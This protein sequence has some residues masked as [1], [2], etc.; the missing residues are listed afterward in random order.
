MTDPMETSPM[1]EEPSVSLPA[2]RFALELEFVMA[3]AS[4]AYL[5]Y[6]A[7]STTSEGQSLLLC[8]RFRAFLQ[9][10]HKTW[11]Q[12]DY[13]RFIIYP[14]SLYFLETLIK[15]DSFCRELANVTALS[16]CMGAE[17]KKQNKRRMPIT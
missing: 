14:H 15:N 13:C 2:N 12:P 7:T 8:P 9:Y 3:L 6:L 16:L 11:T 5:H 10:L 1:I 17:Y 4:P